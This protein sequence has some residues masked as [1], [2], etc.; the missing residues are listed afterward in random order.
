M[1]DVGPFG[2]VIF[3][4]TREQAIADG[5]LVDVSET[6]KEAGFRLP[7]AVSR[8]AWYEYVAVPKGS[9][10]RTKRAVSGIF[11]GSR[12]S[13]IARLNRTAPGAYF[14]LHVRNDNRA[15]PPAAGDAES[16]LR[17]GGRGRAGSC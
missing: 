16:H 13:A 12:E 1:R 2:G 15:D 7:V 6:A 5:V 3:R 17:P 14:Q 10:P 8:A 11:S 4:Y 9:S